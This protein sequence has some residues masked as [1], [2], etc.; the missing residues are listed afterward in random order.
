AAQQAARRCLTSVAGSP[1]RRRLRQVDNRRGD[2]LR[3][4]ALGW[5]CPL[6][7]RRPHRSRLQ[8]RRALDPC[9]NYLFAGSDGGGEHWAV[10]ASLIETC[11]MNGVDPQAYLR[12]VLARIVARHPMGRIDELLPFAYVSA[13]DKAAA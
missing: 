12:D 11:K 5:S 10:I 9:K 8:C 2:P 6:P 1:A 4:L 13:A 7:R 3:A